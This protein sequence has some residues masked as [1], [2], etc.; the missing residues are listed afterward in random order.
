MSFTGLAA[1]HSAGIFLEEEARKNKG[2]SNILQHK[3][4]T[5]FPAFPCRILIRYVT[6]EQK[7]SEEHQV[8]NFQNAALVSNAHLTEPQPNCSKVID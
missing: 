8:N 4:S 5:P 6:T 1:L 7:V 2:F 3:L